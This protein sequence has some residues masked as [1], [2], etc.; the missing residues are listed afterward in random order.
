MPFSDSDFVVILDPKGVIP[1]GGPHVVTRHEEYAVYLL[2]QTKGAVSLL[3]LTRS[4]DDVAGLMLPS[5]AVSYRSWATWM[6]GVFSFLRSNGHRVR[7]IVVGD[8]WQAFWAGLL[9]KRISG[10]DSK[11][12]VQFHGDFFS[13]DWKKMSLKNRLAHFSLS[14]VVE[15][16]DSLRFVG[17][18]QMQNA[19]KIRPAITNK[20]FVSSIAPNLGEFENRSFSTHGWITIGVIGRLHK[21]RGMDSIL[22][23]LSCISNQGLKFRVLLI[24]DGPERK[25]LDL[26][27]RRL[28]IDFAMPGKLFG[29]ALDD[30]WREID[31]V[32]SMAPA[33]SFGLVPREA[34]ARGKRVIGLSSS[35]LEEL[36]HEI[37]R[38]A[39]L[40]LLSID[41]DCEEVREVLATLEHHEPTIGVR[42]QIEEQVNASTKKLIESWL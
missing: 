28:G 19:L 12:Q 42:K 20:S 22:R 32:I 15:W 14:K 31:V 21:D 9:L 5:M 29:R 30:A 16:S 18:R 39:G 33:E 35:G 17:V 40:E 1:G 27:L 23:L 11:F 38:T 24:G 8:P 3:I 10:V 2:E 34:L 26:S 25:S 13:E 4:T 41:W 6:L 37:P 7:T 36:R